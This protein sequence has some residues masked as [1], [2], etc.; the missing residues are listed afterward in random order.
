MRRSRGLLRREAI[1]EVGEK[2]LT[3]TRIPCA[4]P[5]EAWPSSS[6]RG[7]RYA[8]ENIY[9]HVG[10]YMDSYFALRNLRIAQIPTL[11]G[12]YIRAYRP[13]PFSAM[14]GSV[15]QQAFALSTAQ[16]TSLLTH[17]YLSVSPKLLQRGLISE[18]VLGWVLTA[19][20]VSGREKAAKLVACVSD[21]VKG[22]PQ[23]FHDFVSVLREELFLQDVADKLAGDHSRLS[24]FRHC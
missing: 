23:R 24:K 17:S 3:V 18:E 9:V 2:Q 15:E 1:L 4:P 14:A 16:L 19:H 12:I 10:I 7:A 20:G 22:S 21:R 8:V 6:A 5:I 13:L 11:R